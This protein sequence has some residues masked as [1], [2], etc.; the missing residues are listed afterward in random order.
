MFSIE[1]RAIFIVLVFGCSHLRAFR[2]KR[3]AVSPLDDIITSALSLVRP[4]FDPAQPRDAS[5][6]PRKVSMSDDPGT[7]AA[8][9]LGA[10]RYSSVSELP[11]CRGNSKICRFIACTAS[12]FKHDDNFANLNLAAQTINDPKLRK[13]ISANPEAIGTVCRDQ[14][15]S[16]GQCRLFSR[17]FQLIDRF[18]NTIEKPSNDDPPIH[19]LNPNAISDDPI[20]ERTPPRVIDLSKTSHS[21]T[22]SHTWSARRVVQRAHSTQ[23]RHTTSQKTAPLGMT[24]APPHLIN[25]NPP[26]AQKPPIQKVTAAPIPKRLPVSDSYD[27]EEN[28]E[29]EEQPLQRPKRRP[30]QATQNDYYDQL[31]SDTTAT[32][33]PMTQNNKRPAPMNCISLLA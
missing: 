32:S 1:F 31:Q 19:S 4:I 20:V 6:I 8:E 2:F 11:L 23:V 12:N 27:Y 13:T 18:M 25:H 5:L 33:S 26:K 15:L 9:V 21:A 29:S 22:G 24:A 14:G 28:E 16:E 30:R 7:R 3:Q 10:P 17:G